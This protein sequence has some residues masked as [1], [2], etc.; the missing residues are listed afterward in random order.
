MP[1]PLRSLLLVLAAQVAASPVPVPLPETVSPVATYL[2][3]GSVRPLPGKLDDTPVFN[4]NSP[5]VIQLPGILVST[6]PPD[7][8]DK[9]A[10]SVNLD[11]PLTGRFDIFAHHISNCVNTSGDA[12]TLYIGVL[13]K[14]GGTKSATIKILQAQSYLSQPDAPF[15]ELPQQVDNPDGSIF[16]G[17]GDRVTDEILRGNS[18]SGWPEKMVLQPGQI[19]LLANLP[20]PVAGLKPPVNGRSLLMRLSCDQPVYIADLAAFATSGSGDSSGAPQLQDWI[21]LLKAGNLAGPR[22][23]PASP[24]G[25]AGAFVYG[26]VGGVSLGAKWNAEVT[27]DNKKW[28]AVPPAGQSISYAVSTVERGTLGTGQVQSAPLA[29][30][31]PGTAFKGNGNYGVEYDIRL[32]LHN[33]TD[34]PQSV[35]LSLQTPIKTEQTARGLTFYR[36]PP[37]RIFFRGTVRLS[38]FDDEGVQQ[39]RYVHLVEKQ[40][41]SSSPLLKCELK[42]GETREVTVDLL[43]PPDATPPQALTITTQ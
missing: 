26:R 1:L 2:Q 13:L 7:A 12:R 27:D 10:L 11:R 9:H 25:C 24:P 31:M 14:N 15:I 8:A 17:P 19:G 42:A 29:V 5:E 43:Y 38:Y 18:Q 33:A 40:G 36:Q 23:A 16:A 35:S 41:D 6:M 34:K 30:R 22:E 39:Q 32:P 20:I 28:L 4:S 3:P 37:N 21:S